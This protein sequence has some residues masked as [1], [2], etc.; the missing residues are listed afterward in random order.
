MESFTKGNGLLAKA[1]VAGN[2]DAEVQAFKGILSK[3]KLYKARVGEVSQMMPD[4]GMNSTY[5][6]TLQDISEKAIKVTGFTASEKQ[7]VESSLA[8]GMYEEGKKFGLN[9]MDA[10]ARSKH[11]NKI[12]DTAEKLTMDTQFMYHKVM[13]PQFMNGMLGSHLLQF[14]TFGANMG[15]LALRDMLPSQ[16]EYLTKSIM[17][18]SLLA[19]TLTAGGLAGSGYAPYF[20]AID[21]LKQA[22]SASADPSK[23]I[24][25]PALRGTYGAGQ[26]AVG[27]LTG[28]KSL[29]G[30]G[31]TNLKQSVTPA[32]Y[33]ITKQAMDF[34]DPSRLFLYKNFPARKKK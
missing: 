3:S 13:R 27:G 20:G 21:P 17:Q 8:V 7:L 22:L 15:N 26:M 6:T 18:Q 5:K 4:T 32:A 10:I 19:M 31:Q 33:K 30:R 29:V 14:G 16:R 11:F 25:S 34:K 1:F 24:R 12:L 23:S 2:Q 9:S 28:S